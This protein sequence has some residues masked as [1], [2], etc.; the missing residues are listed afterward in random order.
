[1][2]ELPLDFIEMIIAAFVTVMILS[3]VIGD[4]VLFRVATYLFIGVA[5]G[6]AGAIAWENVVKP[7]LVQ[8][9]IDEG[10]AR[11]FSSEGAL[12]FLIPWML[13]LFLFFKLSPRLSRFGSFPVALLVGVGAAVVVGGSITGTLVP[14]SLAATGALSTAT[15]FPA[16]GQPLAVWLE[17]LISALI[18]ILATISVLIYFRFSARRELTG[19]ARRSRISEVF[20]YLGKVFIAVTFGVMYAGALMAT[21][22]V[23]AQRFQFLHD[24]VT[25]IVGG[26]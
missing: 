10:P 7:T 6:F 12:T 15:A 14:Q 4:N 21:I 3:Y 17:Q 20:A 2:P 19:G 5:S 22:A 24:V 26:T 25:N 23:L 13:V 11:L 1:M 8:P 9:L 18:S 16:P